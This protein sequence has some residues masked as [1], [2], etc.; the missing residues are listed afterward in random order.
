MRIVIVISFLFCGVARAN[1]IALALAATDRVY[2]SSE[3][4]TVGISP[5]CAEFRGLFTFQYRQDVPAP[6]SPSFVMLEIPIWFP[7]THPTDPSVASFWKVFPRDKVTEV[8][9]QTSAVFDRAVG[10]RASLGDQTLP[11]GQFSTL[12]HTNNKQ[13]W[14]DPAWQQ[15]AGFC[16]LVFRFYLKDDSILTQKPLTISYRQPLLHSDGVARFF[17]LPDFQNLPKGASTANTDRYAITIAARPG[18]SVS[19]TDGK[20]ESRVKTGHSV[21]LSPRHHQA[22]RAIAKPRPNQGTP[23]NRRPDGRAEG[24]DILSAPKAFG[25]AAVRAFPAAVGEPWR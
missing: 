2:M 6:G 17:Y 24:S 23:S 3:R 21:T 9:P 13:R 15:E 14:A 1:P 8:T 7:E 18:C 10:L 22:I 5:E 11:V 19:V 12:T 4:L 20:K 16:C 25:V